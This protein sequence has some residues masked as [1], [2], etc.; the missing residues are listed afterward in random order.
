MTAHD[1]LFVGRLQE[2]VD[3][4]VRCLSQANTLTVDDA[5]PRLLSAIANYTKCAAATIHNSEKH[6]EVTEEAA[7]LSVMVHMQ[8][9]SLV[10]NAVD[11]PAR[12]SASASKSSMHTCV[13]EWATWLL[14]LES[15]PIAVVSKVALCL[16][17]LQACWRGGY[18]LGGA[19]SAYVYRIEEA[20][21][22]FFS[23][24][25]RKCV[26]EWTTYGTPLRTFLPPLRLLTTYARFRWARSCFRELEHMVSD[27]DL[28]AAE[29]RK[30]IAG[31]AEAMQG[32]Q[33]KDI[34]FLSITNEVESCHVSKVSREVLLH[35]FKAIDW[36]VGNAVP[37][38]KEV[39]PLVWCLF[40]RCRSYA[41]HNHSLNRFSDFFAYE[42]SARLVA[43]LLRFT[44]DGVRVCLER[45]AAEMH[46][47]RAEQL[48]TCDIPCLVL[49]TRLWFSWIG[50]ASDG[51]AKLLPHLERSLRQLVSSTVKLR[52]IA[53]KKAPAPSMVAAR[54]GSS[55]RTSKTEQ[56]KL[57]IEVA[58]KVTPLSMSEIMSP[59]AAAPWTA[60][61]ARA[62]DVRAVLDK[63][64]I[65]ALVP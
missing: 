15:Q 47:A 43:Q 49:L 35:A 59:T 10:L 38:V 30:A 24:A 52:G 28:G 23:R 64:T 44:V 3:A 37:T 17:P 54:E 9:L 25:A 2:D 13:E 53:E 41:L 65:V 55:G 20:I 1:G 46:V 18:A 56:E 14:G 21:G 63:R 39:A 36:R 7:A 40:L 32:Q 29:V 22:S 61:F 34:D 12:S 5:A 31:T 48:F 4:S 8:R 51:A 11:T 33:S 6:D 50:L 19:R 60:A 58:W 45:Q 62:S 27:G 16:P 26:A 42:A 57:F